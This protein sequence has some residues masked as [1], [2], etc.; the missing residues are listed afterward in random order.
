MLTRERSGASSG[1]RPMRMSTCTFSVIQYR[2]TSPDRRSP[3]YRSCSSC[4]DCRSVRP[5]RLGRRRGRRREATH[6]GVAR[7]E[8]LDQQVVE[9]AVVRDRA[10][11]DGGRELERQVARERPRLAVVRGAEVAAHVARARHHV[12]QAER[13]QAG[14]RRVGK[15]GREELQRLRVVVLVGVLGAEQPLDVVARHELQVRAAR[16]DLGVVDIRPVPVCL[17]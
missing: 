14:D 17:P 6:D 16:Q 9:L 10:Q 13:A 8:V 7:V 11:R 15:E 3:P 2:P 1:W 5:C 12:R 4:E